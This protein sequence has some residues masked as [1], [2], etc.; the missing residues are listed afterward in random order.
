[1]T[2][3]DNAKVIKTRFCSVFAVTAHPNEKPRDR[4]KQNKANKGNG[5]MNII[6][7]FY[8]VHIGTAR[9]EGK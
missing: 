4:L 7:R 5:D 9:M 1:M 8:N 2:T 6:S 3:I